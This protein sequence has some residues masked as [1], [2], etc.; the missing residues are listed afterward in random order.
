M[1]RRAGTTGDGE[2]SGR[3]STGRFVVAG[4]ERFAAADVR[5][6]APVAPT[7]VIA[8]HLTYRSRLEEYAAKNAR[9]AVLLHE[10]AELR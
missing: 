9:R 8:V 5:F 10:A 6:L 3:R 2:A 1:E 4:G 7:K